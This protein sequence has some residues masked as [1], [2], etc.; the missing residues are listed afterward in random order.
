MITEGNMINVIENVKYSDHD[1]INIDPGIS[2]LSKLTNIFSLV[3]VNRI[4]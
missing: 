3:D 2:D 4:A 1:I